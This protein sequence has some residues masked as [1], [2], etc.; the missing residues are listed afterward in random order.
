MGIFGHK[1]QDLIAV[2]SRNEFAYWQSVFRSS[3]AKEGHCFN[4]FCTDGSEYVSSSMN[5]FE[6]EDD[7]V[8]SAHCDAGPD[9]KRR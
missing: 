2:C 5:L 7:L 3:L 1:C 8:S 9:Q 4:A 6:T